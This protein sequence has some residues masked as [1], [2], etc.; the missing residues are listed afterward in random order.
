MKTRIAVAGLGGVADRIHLPACR[1][2]PEIEV[3]AG[4]DPDAAARTRIAAKFDIAK[5]FP[6]VDSMLAE[7]KPEALIIG[8]PPGSHFEICQK[9]L[10]AGVHVFC[11]KPFMSDVAESDQIIALAR[12]KKLG[13]RV[14]NQYRYMTYYADAKRRLAAG[15]FGPAYSIEFWQHMFHPPST[16]TNWRSHLNRYVIYE[17]GTHPLDLA[18]FFFDDLPISVQAHVPNCRPDLAADVVVRMTVRFPGERIATFSFNRISHAP[19]KY[20]ESRIDCREAS[21]RIS[22]GGVARL[23]IEWSR[24]ARRPVTKFGFVKGGQSIAERSGRPK[25]LLSSPKPEFASATAEHLRAFLS[26]IRQSVPSLDAA[27]QAREIL[28]TVFAAYESAESGE[29]VWLRK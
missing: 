20:L 16:E 11:E 9:A 23:K 2:V 27:I 15:E 10:Q 29:T 28:R 1:A 17:F 14:N 18:C 5:T 6:D 24:E 12:E 19:E 4:A 25:T 8:T 13:L 7:T 22:L 21:V 26:E 3:V